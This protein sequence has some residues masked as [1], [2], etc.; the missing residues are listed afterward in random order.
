MS[1]TI[2]APVLVEEHEGVLVVT[3]N[4]PQAKNA[5]NLAMALTIA[6]AMDRLDDDPRLQVGIITGAQGSFCS[7]MD[8]KAFLAGERPSVGDRGFGGLVQRPPRKPLIAAVD[9]YALA[10][11]MELA[12]ACDLI[13]AS[14]NARFGIPEAK[15]G[16]VAAAGGLMRLP[17]QMP[18][19]LALELALTGDFLEAPRAHDLG[20]VN[21]LTPGRALPSALDLA[22]QIA[23]NGP[24]A[25]Q[26]SKELINASRLWGEEEMWDRQA[27]ITEPVLASA[28]AIEGAAAFAERRAPQWTGS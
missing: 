13:V 2:E 21:R 5:M 18:H 6:E 23:A 20:L 17:R 15:R 8:L 10:G 1:Q 3:L 7:G 27:G 28:D 22:R 14:E 12:L 24:L 19:R 16:L 26:A 25:V 11:G 9:G 4:R